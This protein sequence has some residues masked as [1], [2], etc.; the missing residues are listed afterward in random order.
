ML[1]HYPTRPVLLIWPILL[2]YG[3]VSGAWTFGG[4]GEAPIL[5]T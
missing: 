1:G 5:S 2:P 3:P 4:A